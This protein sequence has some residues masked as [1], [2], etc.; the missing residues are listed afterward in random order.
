M[1]NVTDKKNTDNKLLDTSFFTNTISNIKRHYSSTINF[2]T[3]LSDNKDILISS[4][5]NEDVINDSINFINS[6]EDLQLYI[7][8]LIDKKLEK[9][10]GDCISPFVIKELNKDIKSIDSIKCCLGEGILYD[11][12]YCISNKTHLFCSLCINNYVKENKKCPI[13]LKYTTMVDYKFD[14]ELNDKIN[15]SKCVCHN[16]SNGCRFYGTI[17]DYKLHIASEECQYI[18]LDCIYSKLILPEFNYSNE[19]T[20]ITKD[21][22]KKNSDI[23][24]CNLSKSC[25]NLDN[26]LLLPNNI[27]NN[28]ENIHNIDEYNIEMSRIEKAKL[29]KVKNMKK[30]VLKI[31]LCNFYCFDKDQYAIHIKSCMYQLKI[32]NLCGVIHNLKYNHA[33][34]CKEL[35]I[36]C[37]K[38]CGK[39]IKRK[40]Y[41]DHLLKFCNYSIVKCKNKSCNEQITN[42]LMDNHLT[43]EC[44]YR[45]IACSSCKLEGITFINYNNHINNECEF[46]NILCSNDLCKKLIVKNQLNYHIN[47]EC[48][49]E[50]I[51]CNLCEIYNEILI[52]NLNNDNLNKQTIE[53]VH[54]PIN[55]KYFRI[56]MSK[57]NEEYF[58]K[59]QI[60]LCNYA[61]K[62]DNQHKENTSKL[63]ILKNN[64][65]YESGIKEIKNTSKHK[66]YN[67]KASF[68]SLKNKLYNNYKNDFEE[69]I[70]NLDEFYNLKNI[71][72]FNNDDL[73]KLSN[74]IAVYKKLKELNKCN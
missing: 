30:S 23:K 31:E 61:A 71:L 24:S 15:Q 49:F 67:V 47:N 45:N 56:D 26:T 22:N 6:N 37:E 29:R 10:P 14:K 48:E 34:E 28:I 1:G 62:V 25:K 59:H 9:K 64:K 18:K 72:E 73:L 66:I 52:L 17:F 19:N 35:L 50:L 53:A 65:K 2:I 51:N 39:S 42:I 60:N 54:N 55:T 5:I 4:K 57:H 27:I 16:A 70:D 38:N 3:P 74:N 7:D 11:P 69:K 58:N 33:I 8:K 36:I 12:Y 32:C 68:N 40:K 43:N 20:I 21:T 63:F 46:R 41:N 13:D 44:L